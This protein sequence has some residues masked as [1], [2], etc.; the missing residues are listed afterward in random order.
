MSKSAFACRQGRQSVTMNVSANPIRPTVP[1]RQPPPRLVTVS[2]LAIW[3]ISFESS[4]TFQIDRF[5][6]T[7][8]FRTDYVSAMTPRCVSQRKTIW[9][10]VLECL[11]VTDRSTSFWKRL[12]RPSAKGAHA[13]GCIPRNA[14]AN[15]LLRS[16]ESAADSGPSESRF[17][18]QIHHIGVPPK[19]NRI[20][21]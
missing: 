2:R 7:R 17:G 13:S 14:L 11:A 16:V 4:S 12:L 6:A 15:V 3:A 18:A 5:S 8:S 21:G 20:N 1:G 10:I 9:L 19:P